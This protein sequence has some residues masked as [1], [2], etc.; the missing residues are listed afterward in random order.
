[1]ALESWPRGGSGHWGG[2][3]G[4]EEGG[5]GGMQEGAQLGSGG[6]GGKEVSPGVDS[7]EELGPVRLG[8]GAVQDDVALGVQVITSPRAA[9]GGKGHGEPTAWA[10][11]DVICSLAEAEGM[12]GVK[13]SACG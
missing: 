12:V 11:D 3:E 2:R 10:Y 1:M 4:P 6:V 9:I 5:V 7:M 8:E 13:T